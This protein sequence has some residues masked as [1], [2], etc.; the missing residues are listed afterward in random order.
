MGLVVQIP[1]L[2]KWNSTP[3]TRVLGLRFDLSGF[4][5]HQSDINRNSVRCAAAAAAAPEKSEA[6]FN[7]LFSEIF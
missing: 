4:H 7:V 6:C 3:L 5:L 2:S 1:S